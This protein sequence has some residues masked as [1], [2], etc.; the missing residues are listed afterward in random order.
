MG[1]VT[2]IYN[3]VTPFI[4]SSVFFKTITAVKSP[5]AGVSKYKIL[6]ADDRTWLLYATSNDRTALSL[7]ISSS[8]RL[9]APGPFSGYIQIAKNPGNDP[10]QEKAY[11]TCAGAYATAASLD[12]SSNDQTGTYSLSWKK[13]GNGSPLMMFAL[14]HHIESLDAK[15]A[16]GKTGIQLQTTV[17]GIAT[18][19]IGDSWTLVEPD[20]PIGLGFAPWDP[21]SGPTKA[22]S[23]TVKA[24]INAAGLRELSQNM[25][26][27]INLDSMYFS[28]KALSKF[29]TIIYAVHDLAGNVTLANAGLAQLKVAFERFTSNKQ[30]FPLTYESA[31]GGIVS[32]ASFVTGDANVDFGNTYYNDH[33]YSPPPPPPLNPIA[34]D[35]EN[36]PTD[37]FSPNTSFHWSYFIHAA[38]IIGYL[39]RPWYESHKD[40]VNTLVRDCAN[41]SARDPYFPVS[42]S[43]DWYHGHSWAKGLF[44]S[45]DGKDEESSS[46]DA[47]LA[48]AVKMWGRTSG[49]PAMEA[50]GNLM[51]AVL[52][53]SLA[54]YFLLQSDNAV[55]PPRFLPN[56]VT[57][58]LFENKVDYS[59]Y[60]GTK[61]EFIHGVHMLPN[62]P[63]TAYTR[64]R[65]F[66][67]EEWKAFFDAGRVD[68]TEGG[69]RGILYGNL[70]LVDPK[71]AWKWFS[72]KNFDPK[73]LDGGASLT[74]YLALAAGL[75]GAT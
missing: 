2:A 17:K 33:Q 62:L 56:K 70:A 9:T 55:Q 47:H 25:D 30:K 39:D 22:L 29:A 36:R 46:E 45:A 28:G 68:Q 42:R 50:R 31:W 48:Y 41:P 38:S 40:W 21:V 67:A 19:I 69:W 54:R 7:H 43:F 20:L 27:Q 12:G 73:Y 4:E 11:D 23:T 14:P 53:R 63:S 13:G 24:A 65:A 57:G 52:R 15:S 44:D 1:F 34:P 49:D 71:A 66:V 72:A 5:K 18:G 37:T 75:G 58:I 3:S 60:F 35:N 8:T 61:P 16:A 74:W 6:L 32:T 26:A 10:N 64:S 59:T 51:L